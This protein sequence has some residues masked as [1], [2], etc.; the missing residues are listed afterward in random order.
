MLQRISKYEEITDNLEIEIA[1][2]L[3]KVSEGEMSHESSKEIRAM[4]K[5]IDD[6]ESV[7]DV[8]YQISKIVDN[9]VQQKIALTNGQNKALNELMELVQEA[10]V[11]M[12]A[13]L[14]RS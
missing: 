1:T 14:N 12:N 9:N 10:F 3:T 5:I 13:N 4:L 7:A 6:M 11:E 8:I 2:F